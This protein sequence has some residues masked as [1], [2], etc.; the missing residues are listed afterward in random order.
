MVE[1]D[2]EVLNDVVDDDIE[3]QSE[4]KWDANVYNDDEEWKKMK[5]HYSIL[6]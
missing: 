6:Y 3:V 5:V 1:D 2:A 4:S